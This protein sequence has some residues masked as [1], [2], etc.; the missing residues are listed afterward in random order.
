VSGFFHRIEALWND[1]IPKD[2]PLL[3]R[4]VR[5]WWGLIA[6]G[7]MSVVGLFTML[8]FSD[9]PGF[10]ELENPRYDLSTTIYDVHGKAF[11]RYFVEDRTAVDYHTL[12][13]HVKAGLLA[14]E[15]DRF[16]GHAG[17]DLRALARVA[18]KTLVLRQE[19]SGGG[20]TLSQQLAKL[21][22]R[23]KKLE[24]KSGISRTFALIKT[25][26]SEW[27]VA[28]KLEKSYT[29]EEIMAMYLN[30]FEFIYGAHGIEAAA[31]V[32]FG[33]PQADL[34]VHEAATLIGMLKNPSL[35]NPV[36]FPEKCLQR[37]NVVLGLMRN[38][39]VLDKAAYTQAVQQSLDMSA[40]A[41]T[42][43]SEG[44]APYFRAELTKWLR[45]L[46]DQPQ[47]R[48]ADGTV[49]NVYTDGLK[50]YTTLDLAYQKLAEE[51][52]VEYM[53]RNQDRY[54]RVWKDKDPWT[55]EADDFQ[56]ELRKSMLES[57][58]KSSERYLSLRDKILGGALKVVV[59]KFGPIPL[60]DNAIKSISDVVQGR[61]TWTKEVGEKRLESEHNISYQKL[62]E[63]AEW[64]I[65]I[66]DFRKL[67]SEW[68]KIAQTPVPM[69]IFDYVEGWERD[70]VMS[71][72]DSVKWHRRILQAG[73]LAIE[74][75]SGHV[76]AWVGGVNHK[77]FKYDHVTMRRSV[78][79][80]IKPFVYTQAMAVQK[81]SPCQQYDDIQYSISPSDPGFHVDKEWS[82]ANADERF[83]G[84]KYNL[85]HGL[86]Y[87]KNSITV[88]LLKELGTVA[89]VRDLLHNLGI[90]KNLRLAD[91]RLAVPEFPSICLGAVD[92]TLM[93]MTGAYTAYANSGVFTKPVFVS[94]I[95]DKNGK[96]I[97]R[98]VPDRKTAIN[99][100]Y[101]AVM[102]QMLRNNVGGQFALS[103]KTPVGGKTG[104]TNDYADGWFMAV[105]P[106]LVIG[107]WAGGEDKWIRFL[108]LNDGQGYI[109]ARPITEKFLQK[110]EANPDCG[111]DPKAVF[112]TP[113]PGVEELVNCG[114]YKQISVEAERAML[115]RQ[116]LKK[117]EF[118]N[119]F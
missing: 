75:Q 71:P 81:I 10:E 8:G 77:Y 33:K 42:N 23:R 116:K 87:S 64:E 19:H 92:L 89:P 86:L 18:F 88:K 52:L 1:F 62:A 107:V 95:E 37:R 32:Y 93:E 5:I 50:I 100:V 9:L 57:Q 82:P 65:L 108:T 114:K 34:E 31:N 73:L 118:D 21:L 56:K 55:Y 48:K 99:P 27:I 110:L 4:L 102:L 51:A 104:T 14:T 80:T 112:P 119:E 54:N 30:K 66:K 22:F 38:Q 44:P 105:T 79:S 76:K 113:P 11:G 7:L 3:A 12:S 46:L 45:T 78:G 24:G 117:E 59:E 29:K 13:P 49:Y 68:D 98:A 47:Y 106:G 26:L 91:G 15:D 85:F 74:P 109:T 84:N 60:S 61:S 28:V 36:R 39:V 2:D 58:V 72:L 41:Q 67:Q 96:I 97:Y 94:R 43:Q 103:V 115:L 69:K 101:N 90:D 53:Q 63:S 17:I 25:K 83:T 16:Y 6:G 111:Y 40:F 70:T 35:Y 20:S